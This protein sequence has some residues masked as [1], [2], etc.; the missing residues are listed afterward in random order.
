MRV[1]V[2]LFA[3]ML[4][5]VG[6]MTLGAAKRGPV[7]IPAADHRDSPTAII[8]P[9]ADL[10]DV[11]AFTDPN[12]PGNVVLAMTVNP[13]QAPGNNQF[14]SPDVLY[15]FKI[16]NNGKTVDEDLVIQFTFTKAGD[17]QTVTMVGP[18]K[19][20]KAGAT[21]SILDA[22]KGGIKVSGLANGTVI[23]DDSNGIQLFAGLRD[24]PFFFDLIFG[25]KAAGIIKGPPI[26]ARKPGID[27]FAGF[28][29]SIIAVDIPAKL[30]TGTAGSKIK[31]WA[32]TSRSSATK[33]S[34]K[35]DEK[36]AKTFDQLDRMGLPTV[37]V[38]LINPKT[39][40]AAGNALPAG[41]AS[42]NGNLKDSFNRGVP[43]DDVKNFRDAIVGRLTQLSGD[44]TYAGTTADTIILPD[45]L[46]FDTTSAGGFPNG[47]APSNDV[48]DAVL[49]IVTKGAITT[50]NV[51]ANDVPFLTAFPFFAP[52][53]QAVEA[54][55][56]RN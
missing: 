52:P 34:T 15:Q 24:D 37:N 1:K 55:P 9:S 32:T 19:P 41:D 50:D 38:V 22:A 31:V 6:F 20:K 21:S 4:C 3:L 28:N 17:D 42:T 14:F 54:V 53:H 47:R 35:E 23:P 44:A 11:Y 45:V 16:S 12:I 25:E 10:A 56:A 36:S 27:Y 48:I 5:S 39:F 18:V 8:D 51:A 7:V 26:A 43:A 49:N 13:F 30:L 2:L 33:R 29:V 46:T 40:D